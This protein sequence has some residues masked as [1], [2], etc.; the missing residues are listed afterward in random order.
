MSLYALVDE[1]E[2]ALHSGEEL[3]KSVRGDW[4]KQLLS[5]QIAT[6]RDAG[7]FQPTAKD[8]SGEAQL[9]TGER[10]RTKLAVWNALTAESARLLALLG[11]DEACEEA[12]RRASA[13]LSPRC[14][15]SRDCVIGECA[16]SFVA[17]LRYL[18]AIGED[19]SIVTRH[20]HLL[21]RHREENGRWRRFPF[22]Y[23]VLT[24]SEIQS[25]VARS[26][27]RHAIPA[28]LRANPTSSKLE[29][30]VLRRSRL[31]DRVIARFELH[32]L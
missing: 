23:T 18:N 20:V 17:N 11:R 22:Y 6:G 2:G 28:L 1:I 32:L 29:K 4:V 5:R 16:H 10:L 12:I 7:A 25:E 15:A 26:E 14:F 30:H 8:L 21:G 27:L 13:W 19:P 31:I 9:F 3:R 24:L